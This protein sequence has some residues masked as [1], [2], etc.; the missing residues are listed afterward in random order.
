MEKVHERDER[1]EEL[2]HF[3]I[4]HFTVD[5]RKP[6]VIT[7]GVFACDPEP[8]TNPNDHNKPL[9]GHP[10]PRHDKLQSGRIQTR[11]N[12][13]FKEAILGLAAPISMKGNTKNPE[14][15]F[16]VSLTA[17]GDGTQL[18]FV[19]TIEY[20]IFVRVWYAANLPHT[21]LER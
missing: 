20:R 18:R 16:E 4:K 6:A 11:P 3:V 21:L 13:R 12:L 1:K 2:K 17:K 8:P 5:G 15:W 7:A 14:D 19:L 10:Y 9:P